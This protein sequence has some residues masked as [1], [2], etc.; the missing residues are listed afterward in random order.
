[1]EHNGLLKSYLIQQLTAAKKQLEMIGPDADHEH[2]HQLRVALRRF[3]SVLAAYSRD[4]YAFDAVV[5]SMVKMTNPLRETDVFL[6]SV[7]AQKYPKLH[8]ALSAFRKKQYKAVWKADTPARFDRALSQLISEFS[9]IKLD[10]GKKRLLNVGKSLYASA[11]KARKKLTKESNEKKI[12]EVR[13]LYKQVRYILEFLDASGLGDETK[14]LK[15]VKKLQ[16]RFG[17]IQDAVNQLDWLGHFCNK[18]PSDECR[19]LYKAR[20]KALKR[21]K[22]DF[23]L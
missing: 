4:F 9:E 14:K 20:K 2:L 13:L 12:H 23:K 19:D 1:M 21:L 17:A 18:H 16:D 3:R 8:Q 22:K 7:D 10:P 11:E 15:K 5:K 6:A